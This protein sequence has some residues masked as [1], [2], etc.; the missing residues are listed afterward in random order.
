VNRLKVAE[1]LARCPHSIYLAREDERRLGKAFYCATCRPEG[2]GKPYHYGVGDAKVRNL[3][4]AER[5]M[6]SPRSTRETANKSEARSNFCPACQSAYRYKIEKL[7][8]VE[9]AECGCRWRPIRRSDSD[10]AEAAA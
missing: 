8:D 2:F 3:L 6:G 10:F 1:P 5:Y 9:C 4:M 7:P